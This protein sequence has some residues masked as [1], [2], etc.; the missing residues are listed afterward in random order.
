M[1]WNKSMVKIKKCNKILQKEMKIEYIN[2]QKLKKVIFWRKI[3]GG[4]CL[5]I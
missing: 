5:P 2:R 4:V 1:F 3:G